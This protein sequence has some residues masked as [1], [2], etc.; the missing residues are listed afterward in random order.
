MNFQIMCH[1]FSYYERASTK[2][3][4]SPPDYGEQKFNLLL[5]LETWQL[6]IKPNDPVSWGLWPKTMKRQEYILLIN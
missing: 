5:N 2:Q 6:I 1:V 3:F 4:I